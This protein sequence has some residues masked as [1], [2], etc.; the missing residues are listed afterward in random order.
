MKW[1]KKILGLYSENQ[2]QRNKLLRN[3]SRRFRGIFELKRRKRKVIIFK[4]IKKL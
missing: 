4:H 1:S 2:K 3:S